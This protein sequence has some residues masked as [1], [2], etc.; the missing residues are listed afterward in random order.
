MLSDDSVDYWARAAA[1]DRFSAMA[2]ARDIDPGFLAPWYG[3]TPSQRQIPGVVKEMIEAGYP[4][5]KA[6]R[7]VPQD[8]A[9]DFLSD[10]IESDWRRVEHFCGTGCTE[11]PLSPKEWIGLLDRSDM[12]L[13]AA[14]HKAVVGGVRVAQA[15]IDEKRTLRVLGALLSY[16]TETKGMKQSEITDGIES[17]KG[18]SGLGKTTINTV[19]AEANGAF[20]A[21]A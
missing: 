15:T 11:K 21:S 14:L 12:K 5:L 17:R 7:G 6:L 16:L 8:A 18:K 3:E 13:P 2:L 20:K 9:M 10:M 4:M 19:F 1:W